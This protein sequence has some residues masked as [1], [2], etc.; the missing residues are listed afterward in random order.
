MK[1]HQIFPC[2]SASTQRKSQLR[3]QR[4]D[5]YLKARKG[6]LPRNQHLD[7]RLPVS[8]IVKQLNFLFNSQG[9]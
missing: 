9:L 2:P 7:S 4:Q 1:R 8:R 6:G 5:G 3:T